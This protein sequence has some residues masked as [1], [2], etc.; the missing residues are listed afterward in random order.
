M[1]EQALVPVLHPRQGIHLISVPRDLPTPELHERLQDYY[2]P[3]DFKQAQPTAEGALENSHDFKA[4]AGE[5]IRSAGEGQTAVEGGMLVSSNGRS[6]VL[7]LSNGYH[8][9]EMP[10]TASTFA[11]LHT[12]P[13]NVDFKPSAADVKAAMA[14]GVPFYVASKAG[15][16]M[17]RPSDGKVIQV[18]DRAD[19]YKAQ[20]PVND[21]DPSHFAVQVTLKSGRKIY[22][23]GGDK[24]PLE[25][26]NQ[27]R[28]NGTG[29]IRPNEVKNVEAYPPQKAKS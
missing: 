24:Y 15:L 21:V 18:F 20:N 19:W 9:R 5:A 6:T 10:V 4:K 11:T 26:M 1:A 13:N 17:V 28:K 29:D 3:I 14:S 22:V 25:R 27:I 12:H 8:A 2:H 23:D 7:P 16:F